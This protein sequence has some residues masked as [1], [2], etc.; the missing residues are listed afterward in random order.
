MVAGLYTIAWTIEML[1]YVLY[2][3]GRGEREEKAE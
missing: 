1:V 2:T 3:Y